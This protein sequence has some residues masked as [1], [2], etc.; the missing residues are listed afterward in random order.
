MGT[1]IIFL[2]LIYHCLGN[3]DK[4]AVSNP[5]E[6]VAHQAWSFVVITIQ[7]STITTNLLLYILIEIDFEYLFLDCCFSFFILGSKTL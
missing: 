5:S 7:S 2:I 1:L 3:D 6:A 4:G